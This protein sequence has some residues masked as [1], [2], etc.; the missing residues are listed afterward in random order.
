M[1]K[2]FRILSAKKQLVG[3]IKILHDLSFHPF[4]LHVVQLF[5][6]KEN[7]LVQILH[8]HQLNHIIVVINM[9]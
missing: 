4:F 9:V 6:L 3:D 1:L 7:S 5:T 8:L 2:C